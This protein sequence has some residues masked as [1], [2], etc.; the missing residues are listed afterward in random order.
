MLSF[1]R[2]PYR[3]MLRPHCYEL[4]LRWFLNFLR[5]DIKVISGANDDILSNEHYHLI[6]KHDLCF[7]AVTVWLDFMY[8][9]LK[10]AWVEFSTL[11]AIANVLW[12][13]FLTIRLSRK[14]LNHYEL[15][16]MQPE[17]TGNQ[18][19]L[20]PTLHPARRD[21]EAG[22]ELCHL[23]LSSIQHPSTMPHG[24]G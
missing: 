10:S 16:G 19:L 9:N 17:Y 7:H 3:E 22:L 18:V 12:C 20:L 1:Q 6:G 8:K 5:P 14:C 15:Q 2:P 24:L 21:Q 11:F 4:T 23:F 13:K